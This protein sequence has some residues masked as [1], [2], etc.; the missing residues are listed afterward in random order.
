MADSTE[1]ALENGVKCRMEGAKDTYEI[2]AK[3]Q[4][5]RWWDPG[6]TKK[7]PLLLSHWHFSECEL[8]ALTGKMIVI[9]SLGF[10]FPL[11]DN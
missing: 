2:Q 11:L 7:C 9:I 1:D 3:A 10:E 5:N 6:T 4:L 8:L